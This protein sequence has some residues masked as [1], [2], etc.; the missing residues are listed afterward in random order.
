MVSS[1]VN[2]D[3]SET[4]QGVARVQAP[5]AAAWLTARRQARR[6]SRRPALDC[7]TLESICSGVA[8]AVGALAYEHAS[9][10][11]AVALHS[12]VL[13]GAVDAGAV[14][15]ASHVAPLGQG[16]T[17]GALR[18]VVRTTFRLKKGDV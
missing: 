5:S 11:I 17:V 6:S 2:F 12:S 10:A 3:L 9:A 15:A 13:R 8:A 18:D 1:G 4:Q 7:S 14:A 16:T